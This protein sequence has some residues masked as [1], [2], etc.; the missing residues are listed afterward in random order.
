MSGEGQ[1]STVQDK[2]VNIRWFNV[3][4]PTIAAIGTAVITLTTYINSLNAKIE[5]ERVV[6]V[7]LE[8]AIGKR[9]VYID[10]QLAP[11]NTLPFRIASVENAVTESSKRMDRISDLVLASVDTIRTSVNALST[12]VEVQSTKID[13]LTKK[14][15]G[16]SVNPKPT[17]F[18]P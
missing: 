2:E 3:N 10:A 5:E 1:D 7:R 15:D 11:L 6:R 13:E 4:V 17:S 9:Q 12:K 16:L 18:R 14:V 8:E